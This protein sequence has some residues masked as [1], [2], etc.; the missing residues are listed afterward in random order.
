M[1]FLPERFERSETLKIGISDDSVA[2]PLIQWHLL[3]YDLEIPQ[4]TNGGEWGCPV[5]GTR[6][7]NLPEY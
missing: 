6:P 7:R 3:R 4:D 1:A 2:K 5:F